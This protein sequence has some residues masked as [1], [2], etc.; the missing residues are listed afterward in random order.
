[1]PRC[2]GGFRA[3]RPRNWLKDQFFCR[4]NQKGGIMKFGM[5]TL[6]EFDNLEQNCQLCKQLELQFVELNLDLPYCIYAQNIK[7][8]KQDYNLE[9]TVHLSEEYNVASLDN[10]MRL[11]YLSQI[12]KIVKYFKAN[13][14]VKKFNLH[15]QIGTYFSL[16]DRKV[17]LAEKFEDLYLANLKDSCRVLNNLAKQQDVEINFENIKDSTFMERTVDLIAGYEYLGFTLDCGHNAK[18]KNKVKQYF[19]KTPE[20]I[21]HMHLHDF[22][23]KSDHLALGNG[24]VDI[25]DELKLAAK[26]NLSVVVE[27]KQSEELSLSVERLHDEYLI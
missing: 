16:P 11:F 25:K 20:K 18:H 2:T 8:L 19:L 13:A 7:K 3:S 10:E 4:H 14:D 24:I 27:V 9:F 26:N 17:Y 1:M 15:I 5:P 6:V 12:E 21:R 22:D 23:G